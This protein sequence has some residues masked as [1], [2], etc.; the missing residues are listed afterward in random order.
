MLRVAELSS[1]RRF[2]DIG[3]SVHAG[4]VVGIAGL[5]GAGRTDIAHAIFG[6]DKEAHGRVEVAGMPLGLRSP[7][8]RCAPASDSF[9][10]IGSGTAWC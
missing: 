4:E 2:A 3:F 7:R 9:P 8:R 6:L 10:K 5:V 1:P